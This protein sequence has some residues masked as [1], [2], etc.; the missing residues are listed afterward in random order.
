MHVGRAAFRMTDSGLSTRLRQ[1]SRRAGLMVGIT[2]VL[3]IAICIFGAALLFAA[4]SRPFS[5]LIPVIAPA[6]EVTTL[7]TPVAETEEPAPEPQA[8]AAVE[9]TEPPA[10]AE[11][12]PTEVAFEP[13]HQISALTSVNF[14]TGPSVDDAVIIA[15]SPATPL[16]FLDEEE[17]A[18][19]GENWMKFRSESGDEGWILE[20]LIGP[21]QPS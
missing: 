14:R 3:A 9:P 20:E 7:E 21:Y 2:M 5:D 1:Q 13:T 18:P 19:D 16:Q 8:Q 15:L 4:L 6:A 12:A 10:A 17:A 11:A